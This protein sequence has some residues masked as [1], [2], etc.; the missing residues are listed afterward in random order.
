MPNYYAATI[1]TAV[2]LE[3]YFPASHPEATL[4]LSWGVFQ[5]RSF[6]R[7][8]IRR[9]HRFRRRWSS[10]RICINTELLRA[11]RLLFDYI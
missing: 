8:A 9:G 7:Q 4:C 10:G 3:K 5:Q 2:R 6:L 1:I 11:G